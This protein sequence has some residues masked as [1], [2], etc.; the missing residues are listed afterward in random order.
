MLIKGL[1]NMKKISFL[2][3]TLLLIKFQIIPSVSAQDT[4]NQNSQRFVKN[5]LGKG[6]IRDLEFSPDGKQFAVATTIGVWI[7]NS[8]TGEIEN[9]FEGYMG[10]VYAISY[11][12]DGKYIAAAHDDHTIRLW[13]PQNKIQDDLVPAL[14]GHRGEI[15]AVT[16]SHDHTGSMLASASADKTIRLW[17]PHTSDDN[18]KL[19]AILPY[20]DFVRTVEFSLDNK[21]LAGGSDD[22]V[23]QIWDAGTGD[24]IY[25]FNEHTDSVQ[26]VH[27]SIDRTQLVSVSLD[28]TAILWSLVGEGGRLHPPIQHNSPV[29]TVKFSPDGNSFVTGSADK[30]IR[31]WDTNTAE[32]INTLMGHKDSVSDID[33]SPDGS[34]LVSG[35]SDGTVFLWDILGARTRFEILGHTG[36]IKALVYTADNRIRACGT[37][38]DGKLRIWDAGTS[39]ELSI[40]RDHIELTQA[41]TFSHDGEKI[42]SG[43]SIDGT[44]FLSDVLEVL[45][46]NIFVEDSLLATFKGNPHGI[47][48]LA[49]SPA[50]TILASG[51]S[52]GRIHLLD[53]SNSRELRILRGAQSTV[54]ALAFV[55]DSTHLF[56]GEENGTIRRWD[57]LTGKEVG[58]GYMG[59][60]SAI[61]ALAFSP[62]IRILAIGDVRGTIRLYDFAEERQEFI[63]TQHTRKI[64]TLLFSEDNTTL[65][66]GSED[67]TILLWDMHEILKDTEKQDNSPGRVIIPQQITPADNSKPEKSA[68]EIARKAYES[69]V[70]LKMHNANGDII[71]HGTGFFVD[72]NKLA[73]N[74]HVIEGSTSVYARQIGK[75]NW[76]LIEDTLAT[77]KD[78]DLAILKLS[79]ITTSILSL[80]NSDTVQTGETVY[81]IGN[82]K[83]LEGTFSKGIVSAVRAIGINKWI[84]IDASI[85]PGSSGGAVQNS[86][87][88]VIGVVSWSHRDPKAQNLNFIVPS[89]YLKVLLSTI[90]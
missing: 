11:S 62:N 2:I 55:L 13:E 82:P 49:F 37:G 25:E 60:F 61:T 81:V 35:S 23:I 22:G 19:V 24:R 68:E 3:L 15:Y 16:F 57:S 73:T 75:E 67:G 41:V 42:A 50:N 44:I 88:E 86:K 29:Y 12:P 31:L 56:S 9:Q 28:G 20:N 46:N 77:D 74:Y 40:I 83:G 39:S 87:G 89:N 33:Y 53:V 10:G 38:L 18:E 30:L 43:G 72:V 14:R 85:S 36:G 64:T 54:T 7:Y 45:R 79:G 48:A 71:G 26:E 58:D 27:F 51:G 63:V 32:H 78:H 17:K 47:T 65:I 76:H 69:T 34:S 6:W 70:Y 5:R 8:H 84:Q 80:A 21:M 66:S 90:K 4:M 52:D 1:C 59:S